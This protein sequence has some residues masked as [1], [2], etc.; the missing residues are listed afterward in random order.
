MSQN[1]EEQVADLSLS[2][3]RALLTELLRQQ[4]SKAYTSR[5]S[6]AQQRL[7]FLAQ[8]E[9][10]NPSYN[11]RQTLRLQ[12]K[13]D[14]NALEDAINRII[15][16]HEPLRTTFKA[17]D[18]QPV[19][20]VSG[21]HEIDLVFANLEDLPE[22]EREDEARRLAIAEAWRPFDLSRDY[23]L[24]AKLLRLDHDLHWLLLTMHHI[25]GDG[26]SLGILS[27]ELSTIYQ[28]ITTDEAVDLPDL[29]IRYSDFAEWQREW[30]QGEVFEEQR[31]YWLNSL[32]GAPPELKLPTDYP[33]LAQQSFRGASVS[34]RLPQQLST[35]IRE[36]SQREG[37]TLFMTMLAAFQT[38]L[39]RYT[40][41]SDIVVG[42]PIAGRNRIEIENLIGFFVNTLALRTS[43]SG[44]STFREVLRRVREVTLGAY[45]HQDMP[46]EE[47]VR[48]LNP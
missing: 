35:S 32:A 41:Q 31:K 44:D 29:P 8:L 39:F 37:A 27:K 30:L 20:I 18:G 7:W 3:K 40:G 16:R 19:Q 42:T 5:L 17:V 48:E 28:A 36:L 34:V 24:R 14:V 47:L 9:P 33:R 1:V 23:P 21:L 13:L 10:D 45:A 46:F 12:G 26:W 11:L 15:A 2:E 6:F 38:L 4:T 25:A 43:F 22:A